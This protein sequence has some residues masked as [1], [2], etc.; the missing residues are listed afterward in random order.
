MSNLIPIEFKNQRIMTTRVLAEQYGATEKNIQ[1]NFSNNR[2]RF[3]ENKHYIR[4]EGQALKDFKNSLPDSIGEPLKFAPQLILWTDRGAARHAKILDTDEAWDVYEKLEETYFNVMDNNGKYNLPATYPEA[5]R[6]LA[7]KVEENERLQ[8]ESK[9][10]DEVIE[11]LKPKADYTDLIIKNPGLVTITQIAKDY[12]MS[13][14]RVN[15]I[16]HDLKVQ[17]KQSKQ[18]LLYSQYQGKGYTHSQ[19][20]DIVHRDGRPD[21]KM[22]T[23]WTQKGRMFIYNL[24]KEN[25]IVPIIEKDLKEVAM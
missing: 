25:G 3:I 24:L 4:L 13:G 10:K 12:G 11:K 18:W 9:K 1:D 2:N 14:Q 19:T 6:Q 15:E 17:Y 22:N 16:L 8:L 21:I 5:L 7:D 20:T 23:K